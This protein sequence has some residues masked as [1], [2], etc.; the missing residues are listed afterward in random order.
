VQ[1]PSSSAR[2]A[3]RGHEAVTPVPASGVSRPLYE[4]A[5]TLP[6]STPGRGQF[7]GIHPRGSLSSP[8]PTRGGVSPI[9]PLWSMRRKA[10][11]PTTSTARARPAGG[12]IPPPCP[13]R[14]LSVGAV[15]VAAALF[16]GLMP[17]ARTA[18]ST[19]SGSA[20]AAALRA[21]G[22]RRHRRNRRIGRPLYAPQ[23]ER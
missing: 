16:P 17:A 5:S 9:G 12:C 11:P 22:A 23:R 13:T 8:G 3:G 1:H 15:A 14:R 20:T 10:T 7:G 6:Q 2:S 19:W 21:P 18:M 4:V